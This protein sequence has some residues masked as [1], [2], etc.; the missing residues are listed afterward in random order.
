MD[1]HRV[2]RLAEILV[3]S[4][5]RSGRTNSNPRSLFGRGYFT[6]LLDAGLFLVTFG[7]ASLV[8][9]ALGLGS[10]ALGA[11]LTTLAPLL[12]LV[13]V[14]AV[15]VAGVLFELVT[16]A[17]FTGSDAA[18][19]LPLTPTEY[20]AASASAIAYSY[21]PA[22]ALMLGALLPV[23]LAAGLVGYYLLAALL[24]T[25]GLFEGAVLVEMV[26]AVSQR[27]TSVGLGRHARLALLL[28]A[29]LLVVLVLIFDLSFN[30]VIIIGFVHSFTAV[31]WLTSSVPLFWSTRALAEGASGNAPL[32]A[33]FAVAQIA[34]VGLL[35]YLAGLLRARFWVPI[36]RE[37]VEVGPAVRSGHPVL[38]RV[39][40]SGPE[41][42]IAAKDLRGYGRR[43]EMLSMLVVPVVL[44]LL[45]V[46]EG[47][48]FGEVSVLLWVG[49]V[50]GFYALILSL[51]SVGQ[52][53]RSLQ[54]LYAYPIRG[55]NILRAKV[56]SVLVIAYIAAIALSIFAAWRVHLALG[57]GL[58][59]LAACLIGAT[60]LTFWGLAF[61]AR[62]SDFQ[63]RPRPQFLRPGAMVGALGSG[64]V[65]LFAILGPTAFALEGASAGAAVGLAVAAGGAALVGGALAVHW[66][67]TGF[68][69][70][71]RQLPF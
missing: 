70:L 34:F 24:T 19:W 49:W 45:L 50:V 41:A 25:V 23:A 40:L 64:M 21:S 52:E 42:A 27:S 53:R 4:Q 7:L 44:V 8:L 18:N 54:S 66:A 69:Q 59:F 10:A 26:R 55:V 48:T 2:R 20:V 31:E 22:V 58:A 15:L 57:A 65:L 39:G 67:R 61:A 71:F 38:R 1:L 46:V 68:D 32:A 29:A 51:T 47:S 12:P 17:K 28:R 6:A 63:D 62:F 16:T 13:S 30:P 43:R 56:A 14:A 5:L 11:T 36:P 60:V 9:P 3:A 37:T 35:V 33:A